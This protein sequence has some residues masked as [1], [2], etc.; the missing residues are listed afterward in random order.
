MPRNSVEKWQLVWNLISR[1]RWYSIREPEHFENP[2]IKNAL[3]NCADGCREPDYNSHLTNT[4]RS[5]GG[6][7]FKDVSHP[8]ARP[9]LLSSV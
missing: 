1:R 9:P 6:W 4:P 2:K 7:I 5:V 3:A 8:G